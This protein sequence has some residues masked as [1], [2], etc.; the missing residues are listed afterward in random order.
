MAVSLPTSPPPQWRASC[1]WREPSLP[2]FLCRAAT[3]S[4]ERERRLFRQQRS[5]I[6]RIKS[7]ESGLKSANVPPQRLKELDR[8]RERVRRIRNRIVA[9]NLRLLAS[10]AR[11]FTSPRF[12]LD[13]LVSEGTLPLIRA[14]E[15]FDPSRGTRFSTYATHAIRN[16]LVKMTRRESR[17]CVRETATAAAILENVTGQDGQN[18]SGVFSESER[19]EIADRFHDGIGA[20]LSQ[21]ERFIVSARF[22][23][24]PFSRGKTFAEIARMVN[25]SRERVRVLSHRALEKLRHRLQ[26][27][28]GV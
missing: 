9:A 26:S 3:L 14:A 6:D 17:R 5:L 13:E 25:L 21:R 7:T 22:G 28:C 19:A 23:L 27:G 2:A 4:A 16:H 24:G 20:V 18:G 15:L 12:P 11:R 8:C 1:G 10:I